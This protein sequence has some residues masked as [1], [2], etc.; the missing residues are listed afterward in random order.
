MS[1]HPLSVRKRAA[2]VLQAVWRGIAEMIC[3]TI[4]CLSDKSEL[5]LPL[6]WKNC[7]LV[8]KSKHRK[9]LL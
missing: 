6:W 5:G 8:K 4:S 9:E 3:L 1:L 7:S 2:G